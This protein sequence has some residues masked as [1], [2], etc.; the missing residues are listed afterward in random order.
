MTGPDVTPTTANTLNMS[1]S[2]TSPAKAPA[3][4]DES[5]ARP[6][7]APVGEVSG[8]KIEVT[9]AEGVPAPE[10]KEEASVTDVKKGKLNSSL[11]TCNIDQ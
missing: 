11:K 1:D 10:S 7:D 5:A 8:A 3:V 9:D 2:A 4:A 6:A